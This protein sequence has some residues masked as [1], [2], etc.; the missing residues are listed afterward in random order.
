MSP[1]GKHEYMKAIYDR[2]H[3]AKKKAKK[4]ILDEFCKVYECHRKS[5]IRLLNGPAPSQAPA[6]RKGNRGNTVYGQRV[7]A[8]LEGYWKA[9]GCLW[10][11]RLK[12]GLRIWLPWIR[13]ELSMTLDEECQLL[14]M[15]ASTMDR[16]LKV[17][18]D[19][20]RK[21]IY[22][23]TK[24]GKWLRSH[25]P[26]RIEHWDVGKPGYTEMDLVS[27]SG[28]SSAGLFAYTL[29]LTDIFSCWVCR[30]AILG[31]YEDL[32][33]AALEDMRG[34]L[35]FAVLGA[36]VDN[37]GEFINAHLCDYCKQRSI[38]LT[39]GRPRKKNDNAHIEQKNGTHVRQPMG[40]LRYDT[41]QAV[42]AIN[43]LY[44]DMDLFQNLFQ[45]SVKLIKTIRRGSKSRR[46][47]DDPT[48]PLDRLIRSKRGI[49]LKV[50]ALKELRDRTNP[51]ELSRR[52]DLKLDLIYGMSSEF[53][54]LT[55]P[56][57]E[58][59]GR[60]FNLAFNEGIAGSREHWS[61]TLRESSLK[62][63]VNAFHRDAFFQTR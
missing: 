45:P 50:R 37:G 1:A 34:R 32:V 63:Y 44:R 27:H 2:Y 35:P 53:R 36:H 15:S 5:A 60:K 9:I 62:P 25:I 29:N 39:R 30:R 49:R 41:P 18:R 52:I 58:P 3:A 19:Q 51:F 59:A 61:G 42:A 54:R 38:R 22:G 43:E 7:Q 17:K 4:L 24:P 23:S 20:A 33:S 55:A 31:K 21:R 13:A 28:P 47:F 26:I 14:S 10:S 57:R 11:R 8:I 48:T 40:Y 46:V 56:S 6:A 12:K 16:R